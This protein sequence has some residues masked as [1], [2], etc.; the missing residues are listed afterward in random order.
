VTAPCFPYIGVMLSLR[1]GD[2]MLCSPHTLK[3]PISEED[4]SQI[5]GPY[6]AF[7]I[8]ILLDRGRQ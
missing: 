7:Q 4:P 8:N 1:A 6:R 2:S 5:R 3:S